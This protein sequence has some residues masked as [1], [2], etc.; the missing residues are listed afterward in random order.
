MQADQ[1]TRILERR[2]DLLEWNARRVGGE[3]RV[4]LR[5]R[6]QRHEQ[7]LLGVEILEDRLDDHV[8]VRHA[9]AGDI[10]NEPVERVA[11]AARHP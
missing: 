5:L 7:R 3:Q 9:V 2:A 11:H 8:R 1:A 4:G 6:F 10:G